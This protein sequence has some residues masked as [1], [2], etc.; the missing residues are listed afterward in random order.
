MPRKAIP[1]LAKLKIGDVVKLTSLNS[2][3]M[4]VVGLNKNRQL[5][6]CWF[7]SDNKERR[8]AYPPAALVPVPVPELTTE[9]INAL[10]LKDERNKRTIRPA[11]NKHGDS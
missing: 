5:E 2:P 6:C 9:Q 1:K 10:I 8:A 4:T 7:D 3:Q 11:K